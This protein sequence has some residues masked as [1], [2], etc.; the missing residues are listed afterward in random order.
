MSPWRRNDRGMPVQPF[1]RLARRG[2]VQRLA[3]L[4]REALRAYDLDVWRLIPLTHGDNT[5]FRVDAAG[6]ERFVLRIHRPSRKTPQV[7]RSELLWL[8][9]LQHEPD[10][11]V[12]APVPTREGELL[13]VTGV[14]GVPEPR[15]AVLLRWLPGRF[16]DAG[17]RPAHL[18]RVGSFVARLHE[19][20]GRFAPPAEF[21]RGRLDNLVGKPRAIGEAEAR[22]RVESPEDEAAVLQL[23][24]AVAPREDVANVE[25]LIDRIRAAQRRLGLGPESFGLIHGDLHQWNY[26]FHHGQVRAIDFDDCGYGHYVYDLAVTVFNLGS[27]EDAPRLRAAL[28]GGYRRVRPLPPEHEQELDRF[29]DLRDL[30]MMVWAIEMRDHPAFRDSWEVEVRKTLDYIRGVVVRSH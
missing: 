9:A 4:A 14:P 29:M 22:Q 2:Q 3:L 5:T 17:L 25:R 20:G 18:E 13:T 8:A 11:A 19:L 21:V 26:L 6:G 27:R 23:V 15:M 7:V 16:L 28:L 24:A 30:Q 10:L 1:E 12:P